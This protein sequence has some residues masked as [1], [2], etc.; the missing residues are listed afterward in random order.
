MKHPVG[1]SCVTMLQRSRIQG[2]EGKTKGLSQ[3]QVETVPYSV[4]GQNNNRSA[5]YPFSISF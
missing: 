2:F 5:I 1:I 4:R 3:N